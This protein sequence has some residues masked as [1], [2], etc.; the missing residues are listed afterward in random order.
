MT[1]TLPVLPVS[2]VRAAMDW[3]VKVLAFNSLFEQPSS[4]G[5]IVAGQVEKQGSTVMFNL[6]PKEAGQRGGGIYLWIRVE[7]SNLDAFYEDLQKAGVEVVEP[8][9]DGFWGDRYF[10]IRDVNG[11]ILAFNKMK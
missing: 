5:V 1:G 9:Q 6:N 2:D 11:Y 4:D 8:L 7:E 3:Y 10:A